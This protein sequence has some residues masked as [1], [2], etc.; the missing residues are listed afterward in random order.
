MNFETFFSWHRTFF[1]TW[2][3]FL[4]NL[5]YLYYK[6][7]LILLYDGIFFAYKARTLLFRP[8]FL[9]VK[10]YFTRVIWS[11][12]SHDFW[13]VW[14]AFG[15]HP[16]HKLRVQAGPHPHR[17]KAEKIGCP[18]GLRGQAKDGSTWLHGCWATAVASPPDARLKSKAR[19]VFVVILLLQL[20]FR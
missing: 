11:D 16:H 13:F 8:I 4:V 9:S 2:N 14:S 6:Y 1:W 7:G 20:L 12:P 5:K 19:I 3:N 18:S 10:L 17:T 15:F